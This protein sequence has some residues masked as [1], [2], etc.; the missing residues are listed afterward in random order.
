MP[1]NSQL[2]ILLSRQ[3]PYIDALPRQVV[4]SYCLFCDAMR[5]FYGE[6]VKRGRLEE[7]PDDE[8]IGFRVQNRMQLLLTRKNLRNE[9][10]LSLTDLIRPTGI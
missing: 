4:E 1:T 7:I 3:S 8:Y 5:D 9:R 10:R 6:E 2:L